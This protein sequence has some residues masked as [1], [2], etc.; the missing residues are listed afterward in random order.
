VSWRP[1]AIAAVFATLAGVP[2]AARADA[3]LSPGSGEALAPGSIVEVRWTSL[4]DAPQDRAVDEAEIVLSL[5]GGKTFPIRVTP[6]LRPCASRFLWTVPALA[7]AHV[8]LALRAGVEERDQD[9]SIEVVSADFRILADPDGRV[10]QL[11]RRVAEWWTPSSPAVLSAED[12]LERTMS[13]ARPEIGLPGAFADAA[14]LPPSSNALRLEPAAASPVFARL[15]SA[16]P[17]RFAP[18]RVSGAPTPLRL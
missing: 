12:L 7:S 4:C 17:V 14:I 2:A 6:E 8:R 3:F 13:P 5:D 16:G 9:E 11:R 10:E 18:A 1:A 15:E